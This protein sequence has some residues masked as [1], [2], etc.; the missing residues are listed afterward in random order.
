M[1]L[2]FLPRLAAT[3]PL[4]MSTLVS[5]APQVPV[6]AAAPSTCQFLSPSGGPSPIQ[7][8]IHIQF[9]NVHFAR[10]NPNVPSDLEQMPHLLNFLETNGVVLA[11]EHTQL[12]SHT[13][14]GLLSGLTGL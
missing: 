10:D 3:V 14:Y 8:V 2:S 6:A 1:R 12:I 5:T 9:D 7:H 4:V 11:N 13:A